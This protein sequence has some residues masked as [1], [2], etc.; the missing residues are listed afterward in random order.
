MLFYKPLTIVN[1]FKASGIYPVD[2][3]AV[4]DD[5]LKLGFTFTD[6]NEDGLEQEK[7][8]EFKASSESNEGVYEETKVKGALE[9]LER[10]LSTPT[11][12][13]YRK[14][15]EENYNIVGISPIFDAY[16]KLA[17]KA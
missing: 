10:V 3:T 6:S 12:E 8:T 15:L 11:K 14:R 16:K 4:C 5:A 7:A 1:S 13:T 2:N 17:I 9:A